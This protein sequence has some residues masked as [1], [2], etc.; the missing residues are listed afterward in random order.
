MRASIR[1]RVVITP[2][3]GVLLGSVVAATPG[4]AS[5]AS[6]RVKPG[7]VVRISDVHCKVGVLL[8]Q[9]KT[10]YAGV[11]AS[12]GALPLNEGIPQWGCGPQPRR[13]SAASAPIGTPARIAGAKHRA[14]LAYDSF[15]RMQAVGT[16]KTNICQYN[17]L[18][19]LKLSA[20]DS[21]AARSTVKSVMATA[22]SAGTALR[23]GAAPA[24]AAASTHNGWVIPLSDAPA[25]TGSQVGTPVTRG[26]SLVGMLTAVPQGTVM[27]TPAAAYNLARA[28]AFA[29]KA[30]CVHGVV[31]ACFDHLKLL[32][33]G[34]RA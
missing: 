8:H 28:I 15:I 29:R 18:I 10:V 25:V 4:V 3:V 31:R 7:A 6:T 2:V 11:P 26:S 34:Q 1:T 23:L 24:T 19:L 30:P 12:C 5:S 20:A 17:D 27:K 13:Q 32:K 14:L 21:R 16:K 33:A 9:G 22:P